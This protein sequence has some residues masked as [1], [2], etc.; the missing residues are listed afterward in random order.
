MGTSFN[1]QTVQS[2]YRDEQLINEILANIQSDLEAKV[3]RNGVS[4]N[5][6]AADFDLGS[7]R[8]LNVAQ[9]VL[10]T[11]GV[12]L[13]Q[14]Q[15]I[16]TQIAQTVVSTGGSG[17]NQT[18]G[19]PITFNFGL[20]TGSQGATNRTVFNLEALF[21]VTSFLGLTVVVNG[22]VQIPGQAYSVTG[23]TVT[24]TESL[25]SDTDIMFIFGDLSPTPTISLTVNNYDL[26]VFLFGQPDA[27]QEIMRYVA[28]R[29]IFFTDD[30]LESRLDAGTAATA[31]TVFDI[32]VD[33]VSVGD[34]TVAA[35]GTTGTF[36]TDSGDVTVE[37][38]EVI[39]IVAPGTPDTTI[40]DISI[41]L[42]G[43]RI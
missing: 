9:G 23:Q 31:E 43:A 3:D 19:D 17:Q 10:G 15:N 11:D 32:Q 1:P 20:A 26:G 36:T 4:P 13:N 5:A 29:R 8:L 30:F 39:S 27:S 7:N 35:A 40:A 33:G 34:V 41:T 16:A 2:G 38:G 21:G 22:V 12:N 42:K 28:P 24:F 37:A 25:D 6:M 18:T 14:V